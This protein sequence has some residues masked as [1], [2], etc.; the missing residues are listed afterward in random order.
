M[1]I[2]TMV[3][4]GI[5]RGREAESA[6]TAETAEAQTGHAHADEHFEHAPEGKKAVES[7]MEKISAFIPS[8]IIGIYVA[9]FG[10][11]SPE[12]DAG[13]WWIFG[14]CFALIPVL[15]WLNYLGH[16]KRADATLT[17]KITI[18]LLVFAMIAFVAWAAAL[19]GT[20]F[21]TFSARATAFGGW[22]VIILAVIMYR[23]ADLLDIVPKKG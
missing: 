18:V 20:P 7:A 13:K 2:A 4:L 14:V 3:A 15:I 6:E 11:L 22:A 16:K 19:P 12:S 5:E 8:E 17:V 10:I 23:V 1:S 21:L 9:G